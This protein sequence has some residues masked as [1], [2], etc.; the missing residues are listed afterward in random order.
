MNI[1]APGC[2]LEPYAET[3]AQGELAV[4][5]ANCASL[6][7]VAIAPHQVYGPWDPLFLPNF[8]A[9]AESG[10]LR[11]FGEGENEVSV[12]FVDNY[13]HGLVLGFLSLYDGSPTLC[14]D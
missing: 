14:G 7:T 5:E 6:M 13:C 9:A 12:C 11:V 10:K 1:C 2:F 3:K 8:L 4:R